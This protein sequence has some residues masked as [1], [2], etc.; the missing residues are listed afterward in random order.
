M[1]ETVK[2]DDL[3]RAVVFVIIK[4]FKEHLAKPHFMYDP[5]NAQRDLLEMPV[6]EKHIIDIHK[7]HDILKEG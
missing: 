3:Q 6:S 1:I 4:Q 7:Q 2:F 5:V